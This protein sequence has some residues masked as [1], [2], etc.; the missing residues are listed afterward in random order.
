MVSAKLLSLSSL[1]VGLFSL[2][3]QALLT[4]N[5]NVNLGK[6]ERM[7]PTRAEHLFPHLKKRA[8]D[9]S[10][11]DLQDEMQ[12]TWTYPNKDG[13]MTVADM[14]LKKPEAD[15]PLLALESFDDLT[16]SIK[17]EDSNK[18]ISVAFK[19]SEA[20]E[21]AIENWDYVNQNKSD[22]FYLI[23]NHVGCGPDAERHPYKVVGVDF[24]EAALTTTFSTQA[25]SWNET[26]ASYDMKLGT[27]SI[28]ELPRGLVKRDTADTIIK[29]IFTLFR[30]TPSG[31][32]LEGA[33]QL[34]AGG[35]FNIDL[36]TGDKE[37]EILLWRSFESDKVRVESKCVGCYT[38]GTIQWDTEYS[39]EN[40]LIGEVVARGTPKGLGGKIKITT[41]I[42]ADLDEGYEIEKL[43]A[44]PGASS[45]ITISDVLS[46]GW[47]IEVGPGFELGLKAQGGFSVGFEWGIPDT[48]SVEVHS[49]AITESKS[50]GFEGATFTPS[51]SLDKLYAEGSAALYAKARL[52]LG[53]VIA[54]KSVG[55][56]TDFKASNKAIIQAGLL[57]D[58]ACPGQDDLESL[59][60]GG[61]KVGLVD[62]FE[63]TVAAGIEDTSFDIPF[64]L[65]SHEVPIAGHCFAAPILPPADLQKL[66]PEGA[67]KANPEEKAKVELPPVALPE[68]YLEVTSQPDAPATEE[69]ETKATDETPAT[70]E[71]EAKTD[72]EAPA[73]EE[74]EISAKS[75][76][77][78]PATEEPEAKSED[79]APA[80]E[81]PEANTEETP[82]EE[83]E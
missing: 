80:A 17:C 42:E 74:S 23:A 7:L 49:F 60:S 51:F 67:T 45:P 28:A 6:A 70:E 48:A 75:E 56:R 19:S 71:P 32:L 35:T 55:V 2:P 81:E 18:Q 36:S 39:M 73:T 61:L 50:S 16:S 4:K 26:A 82:A 3:A 57:P 15:H 76:D 9:L 62:E 78:A 46:V 65:W 11:L 22:F 53:L 29:T 10:K 25:T 72:D 5:G 83:E 8:D 77:E 40:G 33:A 34:L 59:R 30:Q 69:P 20:M 44:I 14:K 1:A 31:M 43:I 66:V 63:V 41:D 12:L 13:S 52:T 58:D 54:G 68:G 21:R 37:N 38:T 47:T 27:R 24:N 64:K 79:D